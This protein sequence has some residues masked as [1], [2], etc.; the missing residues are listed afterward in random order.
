MASATLRNLRSSE[1][2]QTA[3]RGAGEKNRKRETLRNFTP[4][5]CVTE[6]VIN[7]K[8]YKMWLKLYFLSGFY[9]S[10]YE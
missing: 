6:T 10:I 8:W 5:V 4:R 7:G 2:Y 3:F 1:H 9:D